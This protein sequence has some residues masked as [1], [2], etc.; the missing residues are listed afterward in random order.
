MTHRVLVFLLLTTFVTLK[1]E[2]SNKKAAPKK[3]VNSATLHIEGEFK[4]QD[5]ELKFLKD[6]LSNVKGLKRGYKKKAKVYNKLTEESEQLKENFESYIGHRVEYEKAIDGY[7]KTI[8]CLKGGDAMKCRPDLLKE[9]KAKKAQRKRRPQRRQ[10]PPISYADYEDFSDNVG[11]SMSAPVRKRP[12]ATGFIREVDL[13]IS[14]RG[15][16]L[17]SCYRKGRYSQQGVLKVQLKIAPNGNLHHLGFEDTTQINDPRVVT[18]LSQVL[19]SI[20]YPETPGQ[21]VTTVRKPF[22]FNWM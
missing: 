1:G 12:A 8:E 17:L 13:R 6:E 14:Q 3:K 15:Q 16:E 19:Y 18:C 21:K 9:E 20:N 7:N 2:A 5:Q 22:V 10:A 11:L 4:E